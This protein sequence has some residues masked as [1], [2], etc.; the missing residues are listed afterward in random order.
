MPWR[1]IYRF[2]LRS[3]RDAKIQRVLHCG[4]RWASPTM[5]DWPR[6]RCGMSCNANDDDDDGGGGEAGASVEA[7]LQAA[8]EQYL[9]Y[10]P[11]HHRHSQMSQLRKRL[12]LPATAVGAAATAGHGGG[13]GGGDAGLQPGTERRYQLPRT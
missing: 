1:G 9:A 12:Q 10:I 6:L 7:S 13:A 5:E 2:R 8:I 3:Q 11:A 4:G